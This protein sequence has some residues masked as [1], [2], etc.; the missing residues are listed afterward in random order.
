MVPK[1]RGPVVVYF[2]LTF[3]TAWLLWVAG[4]ML[5]PDA[6]AGVRAF[7]FL[8]GTFAPGIV[9]LSLSSRAPDAAGARALLARVVHWQGH[10][11]WIAFAVGYMASVKLLAAVAHRL[12]EGAWP[13]FGQTPLLVLVG[14]VILS[15]PFQAG[16][17]I[18]W[19]GYA[20]PRLSSRLGLGPASLLLGIV[21]ACWH[22][23][24]FYIAGTDLTGQP[25]PVFLL[26][27]TAVSVPM[28]YLYA[29]TGESLLAVMLMHSA[30][31][32]TTG[33]VPASV[34]EPTS[35]MTLGAT[36]VAWLT[37]GILWIGAAYFLFRM[38]RRRGTTASAGAA[39][40]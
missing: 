9:A 6:S 12:V 25:F 13:A 11:T 4:S 28:A 16:E 1:L 39:R 38:G 35:P 15:T 18:G 37:A 27:V 30:I 5:L 3:G 14:A 32:N 34:V 21:W 24:L 26:S 33:I 31:N 2:V 22:L 8:P 10:A 19:R 29:K 7:L 20:L 17:E 36:P 40:S 23:P